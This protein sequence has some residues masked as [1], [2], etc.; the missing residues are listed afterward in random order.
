MRKGDTIDYFLTNRDIVVNN[1]KKGI[2]TGIG[3]GSAGGCLIAYLLGIIHVDPIDRNLIFERF[4]NEGRMGELKECKAFLIETDG[5]NVKLNEKSVL[6]IIRNGVK[7]NVMVEDL[8][9]G[10]DILKY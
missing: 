3:R 2:L 9:D 4:L 1:N 10:D 8:V 6:N 7:M 5:G